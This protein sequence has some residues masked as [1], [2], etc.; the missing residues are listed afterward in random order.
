MS[1]I[2]SPSFVRSVVV[3]VKA[4]TALAESFFSTLPLNR[5]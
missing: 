2:K 1:V 4:L 3:V 5:M